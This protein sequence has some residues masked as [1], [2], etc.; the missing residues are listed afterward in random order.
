MLKENGMEIVSENET[1][2]AELAKRLAPGLRRGDAV[3]L[4]GDL[5][6]GKSVFARALVRALSGNPGLEVPSPTFTLVQTYETPAGP[7]GH[8]DL[9][10]IKSPED[11]HELGWDEA[12]AD[13]IVI[14]EWAE[15]L[16]PLAPRDRLGIRFGMT[17]QETARRI[18][19]T[20]HG[21]REAPP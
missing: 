21:S 14:V 20:A 6:A 7:I 17:G 15:R 12:R 10:R 9:Y 11:I 8:F 13:G 5:G 3:C 4:Y 18:T 16:G 1:Q 2:T 19:I